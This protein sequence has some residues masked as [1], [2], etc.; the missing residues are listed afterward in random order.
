MQAHSHFRDLPSVR[1]YLGRFAVDFTWVQNT[2]TVNA[3]E[4]WNVVVEWLQMNEANE[5][6]HTNASEQP[7]RDMQNSA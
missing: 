6:A 3:D 4:S 2:N 7:A 1:K 5:K